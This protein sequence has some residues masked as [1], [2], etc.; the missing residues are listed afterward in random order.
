MMFLLQTAIALV[1]VWLLSAVYAI[2]LLHNS[3]TWEDDLND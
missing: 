3:P 2:W 1:V